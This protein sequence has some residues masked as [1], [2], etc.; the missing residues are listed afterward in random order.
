ML[1]V[2]YIEI[3]ENCIVGLMETHEDNLPNAGGTS[4]MGNIETTYKNL[5]DTFG[6][7]NGGDDGYKVD[8]NWIIMT[9]AGVATI[10]N[11]KDGHNYLGEDGLDLWDITD[12]N[13]GGNSRLVVSW[14]E[15]ALKQ[16]S[17]ATS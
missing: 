11:Y 5:L 6:E 17:T 3:N 12:W 4:L 1:K 14:I 15:N 2:N 9:P 10:Y 13:I 7:P 8:A 16:K